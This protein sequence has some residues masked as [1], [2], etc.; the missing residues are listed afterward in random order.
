MAIQSIEGAKIEEQ[1]RRLF[2]SKGGGLGR[3]KRVRRKR[4][5]MM[6]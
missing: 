5:K 4:V 2:E 3:E 1:L 6:K